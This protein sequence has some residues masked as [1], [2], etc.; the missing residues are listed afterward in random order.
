[1]HIG[2]DATCWQLPRG[3]GRYTR[4]LLTALRQIDQLNDYT[5]FTNAP[6]VIDALAA[7][8]PVRL[9][10]TSKPAIE[11]AA[12]DRNGSVGDLVAMSRALSDP[13]IDVL[14]FPTAFSDVPVFSRAKKVVVIHDVTAECGP[15]LTRGA[16]VSRW[17]R[18]IASMMSRR[19]AD[20]I[21][22]VSDYSR[23]VL[24]EHFGLDR[25]RVHVIGGAGDPVFRRLEH[26][27]PTALL[28]SLGVTGT[29]RLVT[30]VGGFSPH[31]SLSRLIEVFGHLADRPDCTDIDL[32]L[33]GADRHE[34]F[35]SAYQETR[36]RIRTLALDR[37]V[38]LTGS[39][40]DADLVALLNL[41]TV[42]V[43]P[44]LTEE[45]G[46][47]VEAAACGCPVIA[48][49]ESPLPELLGE[50]GLFIDPRNRSELGDALN[51]VLTARDRQDY[52]RR[53]GLAAASRLTW[54]AVAGD[55]VRLMQDTTR[56]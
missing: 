29:R 54:P 52:M 31:E 46:V 23:R 37:R 10:A 25:E 26:P 21:A 19:Q 45:Y 34:T 6:A 28:V 49:I 5:F 55:L 38:V 14:L 56:Q 18:T 7:I 51:R 50:G 9:V 48:A 27:K 17:L 3:S 12:A 41:A 20:A 30:Y 44:S 32:V 43:L 11:G 35:R 42:L 16:R 36:D 33:V 1:M 47:A 53:A 13:S 22:T 40:P 15:G 2:V 8:A 24:V 4:C 39:L